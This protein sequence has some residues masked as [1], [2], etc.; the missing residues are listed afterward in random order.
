MSDSG[1]PKGLCYQPSFSLPADLPTFP[2]YPLQIH[3]PPS[4]PGCLNHPLS[5]NRD[6]STPMAPSAEKI[7]PSDPA[8]ISGLF[9]SH[10]RPGP[11][12]RL[13]YSCCAPLSR[14]FLCVRSGCPPPCLEGLLPRY[15]VTSSFEP[16][17]KSPLLQ[18]TFSVALPLA[19]QRPAGSPPTGEPITT[20]SHTRCL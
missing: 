11:S 3:P 19:P 20:V 9:P 6:R 10:A 7:E 16:Q 15:L 17:L 1:C 18:E 13:E 5:H 2:S 8:C 12:T 14:L 4:H